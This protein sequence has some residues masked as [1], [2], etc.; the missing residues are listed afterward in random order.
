MLNY[1]AESKSQA[2]F[3]LQERKNKNKAKNPW[4]IWVLGEGNLS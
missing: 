4:A 2:Y 3:S 1:V